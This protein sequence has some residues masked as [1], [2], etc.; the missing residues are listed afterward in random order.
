MRVLLVTC[1]DKLKV[2]FIF[3]KLENIDIVHICSI[4][5]NFLNLFSQSNFFP[6]KSVPLPHFWYSFLFLRIFSIPPLMTILQEVLISPTL[7]PPAP[8]PLRKRGGNY[9]N[10]AS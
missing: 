3:L 9:E 8:P 6:F 7:P 10:A 4:N 1:L 2:V 5:E